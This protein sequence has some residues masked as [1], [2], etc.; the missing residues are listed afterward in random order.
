VAF[1]VDQVKARSREVWGKGDYVKLAA[2]LEPAAR[3]LVDACAVSAGQEV[4]DVAAGN[5]NVAVLAAREGA[6]VVALDLSPAMV[7][8]GRMRTSTE[9]LDVEWVE[10]DAEALPFE[11]ARFDAV[12]SVFGAM[13]TPQPDVVAT[14]MLRVA[15]PGGV[16]GMA[17]WTVDG[18]QAH[19]FEAH[20]EY[21]P[22]QPPDVPVPTEE[23]G[24][25]ARVRERFE[26]LGASVEFQRRS[27]SWEFDSADD[28]WRFF[29][30]AGGPSRAIRESL[31]DDR[32]EELRRDFVDLVERWNRADDG[33]VA[34][35][36]DYLI[37]LARRR[38]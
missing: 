26:A 19:M 20:R 10:G 1:D 17:N 25:E 13:L 29:E 23:W 8:M 7:E 38:G 30:D 9:G 35:D 31:P 2:I 21:G 28:A 33:S 15:R 32:R 16:V 6:A 4:L 24:D 11:D 14:E 37:V 5:G 3:E 22:P 12:L 36:G 27:L 34:V 18:F